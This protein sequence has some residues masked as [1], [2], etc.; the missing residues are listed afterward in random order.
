M[1]AELESSLNRQ[2]PDVGET[3]D[4]DE[5]MAVF[6]SIFRRQWTSV[7]EY[8]Q[9]PCFKRVRNISLRLAECEDGI[10]DV[11][12]KFSALELLIIR[13]GKSKLPRAL[14]DIK[15]LTKQEVEFWA[16]EFRKSHPGVEV[17]LMLPDK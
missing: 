14:Q 6:T 13:D 9:I 1:I 2:F 5:M 4:P 16:E 8:I 12:N 15:R 17:L 7:G 3:R 11:V 10:P